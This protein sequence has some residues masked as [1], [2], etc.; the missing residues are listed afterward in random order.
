MDDLLSLAGGLA[1]L[2]AVID[3]QLPCHEA[4]VRGGMDGAFT[5]AD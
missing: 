5:W 3:E 4:T 1:G 2:Q